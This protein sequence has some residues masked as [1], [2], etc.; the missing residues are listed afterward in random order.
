MFEGNLLDALFCLSKYHI[1]IHIHIQH[2]YIVYI[3]IYVSYILWCHFK[4][5]HQVG[6]HGPFLLNELNAERWRER[7]FATNGWAGSPWNTEQW[8]CRCNHRLNGTNRAPMEQ[9]LG[10]HMSLHHFSYLAAKPLHFQI[11]DR[12][13]DLLIKNGDGFH[14]AKRWITSCDTR[15]WKSLRCGGVVS[16]VEKQPRKL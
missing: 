7:C 10:K 5:L 2:I 4:T 11:D 8:C 13:D 6:K 1:Y 15:C 12:H 16:E 3:Y 9:K 14:F